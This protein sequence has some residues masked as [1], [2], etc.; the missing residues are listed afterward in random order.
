MKKLYFGLGYS[1]LALLMLPT[2]A[3]SEKSKEKKPMNI[4][5][6]MTDDHS[7]QTISAYDKRYIETPHIDRIANEGVIFNNSFVANSISGPS[8]ACLLTGKH[9][10]KNGFRDN[11]TSFDGS[12]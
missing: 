8:R 11:S 12:Q 6:I 5:Y 3:C 4:L 2:M 9:S 10:H 1:S 7:Y